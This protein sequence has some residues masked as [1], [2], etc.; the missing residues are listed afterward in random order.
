MGG[1]HKASCRLVDTNA[2]G[3]RTLADMSEA[4]SRLET[5]SRASRTVSD[6]YGDQTKYAIGFTDD[7]VWLYV[8]HGNQTLLQRHQSKH[9]GPVHYLAERLLAPD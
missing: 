2:P 4:I 6:A 3:M 5:L 7:D 8:R 1:D 9:A